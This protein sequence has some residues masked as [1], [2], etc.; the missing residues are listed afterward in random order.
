MRAIKY[1][2]LL[3]YCEEVNDYGEIELS[4][5]KCKYLRDDDYIYINTIEKG[6]IA[7]PHYYT[8]DPEFNV[9]Y[10]VIN[11]DSMWLVVKDHKK[12][13]LKHIKDM[14]KII[15]TIKENI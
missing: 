3:N 11:S 7:I 9:S 1:Q 8:E 4:N 15:N 14:E 5:I 13:F 2:T 6:L 12:V 10:E